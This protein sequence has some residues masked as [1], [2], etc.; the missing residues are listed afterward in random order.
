MYS[1]VHAVIA[2]MQ[3]AAHLHLFNHEVRHLASFAGAMSTI[4]LSNLGNNSYAQITQT[5]NPR[6]PAISNILPKGNP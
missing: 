1:S 5:N 4:S 6:N 2:V 3:S